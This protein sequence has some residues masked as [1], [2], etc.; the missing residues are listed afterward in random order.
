MHD[1][2]DAPM[3]QRPMTLLEFQAKFP[4]T[5]HAAITCSPYAF[6]MDS[7]ARGAGMTGST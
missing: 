7:V 1:R 2:G 6:L 3:F 4:R 5:T